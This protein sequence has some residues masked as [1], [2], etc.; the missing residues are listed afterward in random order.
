MM[1][2]IAL[3][4]DDTLERELRE[5]LRLQASVN[6]KIDPNWLTAGN[7]YLRA[8]VVEAVEAMDHHGWKWWS[9]QPLN[10]SQIQLELIDIWHFVLSDVLVKHSGSLEKAAASIA[11]EWASTADPQTDVT[12]LLERLERMAG[13]GAMR[14]FSFPLYR[15]LLQDTQLTFDSLFRAYVG[16]NVLNHFR[17]DHGYKQGTYIKIWDGHED[18]EVLTE[19]MEA[20]TAGPENLANELY[21]KFAERYSKLGQKA[22]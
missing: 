4:G 19:L 9:R 22:T 14:R 16:K 17:Q 1:P 11:S 18:N 5:M 6:S 8:V 2:P 12:T 15:A 7:A 21:A 20:T 10:M 3:A 13:L